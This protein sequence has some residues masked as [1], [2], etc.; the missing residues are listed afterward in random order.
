MA[1]TLRQL[2]IFLAVAE[3]GHV[4]TAAKKIFLTQSAVSMAISEM[5]NILNGPL[6]DRQGKKLVLNDRGRF[7]LPHA[8]EIVNKIRNLELLLSEP[9][10]KIVGTLHV[11]A[12]T[13]IGNYVM[14]FIVSAFIEKYPEA[15]IKLIVGNTRHIENQVEEGILD[16]GFVG[17]SIQSDKIAVKPWLE[18]RLYIIA[19]S[20]HPLAKKEKVTLKDLEKA[21]WIVR[22]EGSGVAEIFENVIAKQLPKINVFLRLGHTEAI[23][24][25]VEAGLGITCLSALT[26]CREVEHGWIKILDVPELDISHRL[27]TILRK[28]KL[29]TKLLS[30]FMNFCEVLKEC[31]QAQNA[32]FTSPEQLVSILSN[33]EAIP[34]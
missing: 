12:S 17:G 16:I 24:K 1:L 20:N 34:T 22:E 9:E 27:S 13:T 14:P 5:E 29:K 28:D 15:E 21:R 32:C 19:G 11:G 10:D 26:V 2:E 3:T 7:L 23:K 18:D 8:R 33:Y 4:T 25:A 6:F 30:E 31:C